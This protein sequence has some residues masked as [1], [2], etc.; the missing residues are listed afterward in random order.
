MSDL[1]QYIERHDRWK[2]EVTARQ[3]RVLSVQFAAD[4]QTMRAE[5]L[6]RALNAERIAAQAKRQEMLALVVA[7][8]VALFILCCMH[9]LDQRHRRRLVDVANTDPLTGLP[10]RRHILDRATALLAEAR[11]AGVP[12]SIALLDLDHFKAINDTYGHLTGDWVLKGVAAAATRQ[13]PKHA[14][15]GRWGGEEFL[16]AFAGDRPE[17]CAIHLERLRNEILLIRPHSPSAAA[18]NFSAGVAG[19]DGLDFTLEQIVDLAD[20]ALYRAKT[21]GRGQ[22]CLSRV[23]PI[24]VSATLPN[25]D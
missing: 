15:V 7:L 2:E 11:K 22:T 8:V 6:Q 5:I 17:N 3:T 13:L 21:S 12:F 14:P 4:L 23:G 24:A 9:F 19:D 16:I 18:V 10:N 25:S 20:K 1:Y